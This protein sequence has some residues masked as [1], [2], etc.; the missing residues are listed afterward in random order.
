MAAAAAGPQDNTNADGLMTGETF[1]TLGIKSVHW[2]QYPPGAVW[3]PA[4]LSV[5]VAGAPARTGYWVRWVV[6]AIA[7]PTAPWQWPL[8][9]SGET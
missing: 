6:T 7:T 3:G 8:S 5:I 1:D 4:D 2:D 9:N